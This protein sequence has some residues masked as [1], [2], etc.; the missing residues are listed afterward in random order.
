MKI[1]NL[2]L[3]AIIAT[4]ITGCA[5][6][7]VPPKTETSKPESESTSIN[8]ERET[9]SDDY[10]PHTAPAV[11]LDDGKTLAVP[12]GNVIRYLG[13]DNRVQKTVELP[14]EQLIGECRYSFGDNRIF[15]MGGF[16]PE[17]Y[18]SQFSLRLIDERWELTNGAI[19][20][21]D[22]KLLRTFTHYTESQM[23]D[24]STS[25]TLSDGRVLPPEGAQQSS[26][27]WIGWVTD[28]LVVLDVRS[29]LFFYRLS[30]DTLTLADDMSAWVEKYGK[31]S[32][33]YGVERVFPFGEGAFYFAHRNDV[34]PSTD[35][36]VWYADESG[37]KVLFDG[38]EFQSCMGNEEILVMVAYEGETEEERKAYVSY[39]RTDDLILHM[40]DMEVSW[41]NPNSHLYGSLAA[42]ETSSVPQA[43]ADG[44]YVLDVKDGTLEQYAPPQKN[45]Q[46]E[47]MGVGRDDNGFQYIYSVFESGIYAY[48]RHYSATG[49][50]EQL[51]FAPHIA[52]DQSYS[53]NLECY[54]EYS[55]DFYESTELR[56][57]PL[58]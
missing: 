4:M 34:N 33:Y 31:F 21:S 11:W 32:V 38:Q 2:L 17:H 54:I 20:D 39:A 14:E 12:D 18:G 19:F 36:T 35:G 23:P 9:A 44:F 51:Q 58:K 30:T 47:L 41:V 10:Y 42:L 13:M 40:L 28:D 37:A 16:D 56:I 5:T 43:G 1:K 24:G 53:A 49:Q 45:Q 46:C 50:T 57:R 48:Y 52:G 6:Q 55:P 27:D 29:R 26:P 7:E 15:A 3:F 8:S 22:G 25:H